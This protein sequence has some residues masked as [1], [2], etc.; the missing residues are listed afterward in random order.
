MTKRLMTAVLMG[1]MLLVLANCGA[2][3]V[4]TTASQAVD[5]LSKASIS[6]LSAQLPSI[7]NAVDAG[8]TAEARTAFT[9]FI[10]AWDAIKEEAKAAAPEAAGAI[11]T[12]MDGVKQTLVD[13]PTPNAADVKTALDELETQLTSFGGSLK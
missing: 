8:N 10:A 4:A 11:Q 1:M 13:A 9:T 6:G 2:S 12:A 7:E 3:D 5:E